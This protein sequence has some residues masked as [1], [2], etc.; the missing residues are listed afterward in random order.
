MNDIKH[1]HQKFY[2]SK[3]KA[4]QDAFILSYCSGTTP[5]RRRTGSGL[6]KSK[7]I[8]LSFKVRKRDGKLVKVCREAFLGIIG[9]KKDRTL[10]QKV[11][12]HRR[13]PKR[14]SWRRSS[15]GKT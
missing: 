4:D 13:S 2:A 7:T 8:S 11:Y 9:L 3:K 14:E 15:Y 10:R 5:A 12:R 1:F 6:N